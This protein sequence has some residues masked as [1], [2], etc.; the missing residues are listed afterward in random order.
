MVSKWGK[1]FRTLV[2]LLALTAIAAACGGG[3]K[4]GADAPPAGDKAAKASLTDNAND[5]VEL[6]VYYMFAGSSYDAFMQGYGNFI[7]QKYPNYTFKFI[8][9]GKG[10]TLEDMVTSN[11]DIDI[12]ISTTSTL[13]SVVDKKLD[14]DITELVDKYGYDLNR[15]EST[16]LDLLRKASNGKLLGLPFRVNTLGLYY[17]KDLFDKFG[18]PYLRDGMT[19]DEVYE[20]AGQ[21]TRQDGGV[22]YYGFAARPVANLFKLNPYSQAMV[23][24]K[25]HQAALDNDRWKSI[26]NN[27][28]RF[29]Q[30][31]GYDKE[32]TTTVKAFDLFTKEKRVAILSQQNSDYLSLKDA[33]GLNWDVVTYPT[34]KDLP[35]VNPQPE[36][37]YFLI[38]A[39]SKH[40]DEAFKAISVI[41]SDEVQL[42]KSK[43]GAPSPLKSKAI[44]DAYG[45]A[46]TDMAGKNTKAL[47]PSSYA[48]ALVVDPYVNQA[49]TPLQ[50]AFTSVVAGEKDLN[51]AL[52]EANELTN[53]GIQ[54]LAGK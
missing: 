4:P 9:T 5:P 14:Y 27:F 35:G 39:N 20:A 51:T 28:L 47:V 3:P 53:K 10:S 52:R 19:W 2:V 48:E 18:V 23:D 50:N 26:F 21:L 25:T 13:T 15:F 16:P 12:F 24:P 34:Y 46:S 17:N 32:L 38:S 22:Q 30:L 7:K 37:V 40:K 8:S 54:S 43:Q 29:Y 49:V 44:R 31:P 41:L 36:P 45:T 11:T 6:T 33:Q 42:E 1:S